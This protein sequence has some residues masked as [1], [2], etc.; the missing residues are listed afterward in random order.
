MELT[1]KKRSR[2][3]EYIRAIKHI[4]L[5]PRHASGI[6]LICSEDKSIFLMKRSSI[7]LMSGTWAIP[8]GSVK[9]GEPPLIGALR[10]C[11]EEME[12]VPV[13]IEKIGE[14][15]N[16]NP[17]LNYKTY[18]YDI[19]LKS[20]LYWRPRI[21]CEHSDA[22]WFSLDNLPRNLHP[23]VKYAIKKLQIRRRYG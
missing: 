12:S 7:V 4:N 20:K 16:I 15:N 9:A 22:R 17:F 13:P 6:L 3:E 19:S 21:N 11:F 18:A 2:L 10:E 8:G 23:G 1:Y 5:N 14:T